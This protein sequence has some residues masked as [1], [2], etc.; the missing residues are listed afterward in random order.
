MFVRIQTDW[1]SDSTYILTNFLSNFLSTGNLSSAV[2]G[3]LMNPLEA[4]FISLK[5]CLIS[6]ILCCFFLWVHIPLLSLPICSRALSTSSVI[7]RNILTTVILNSLPDDFNICALC[8]SGSDAFFFLDF[9]DAS[10]PCCCST[11][12]C[13]RWVSGT[14]VSGRP[15]E[16]LC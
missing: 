1:L 8:E 13:L 16:G 15:G 3:L 6:S 9:W 14:E 12:T 7:A 2:F 10:Q 5:E 11:L 4:F